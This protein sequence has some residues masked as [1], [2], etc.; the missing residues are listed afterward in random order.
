MRYRQMD[1]TLNLDPPL[2]QNQKTKIQLVLSL[3]FDVSSGGAQA[4]QVLLVTAG[5]GGRAYRGALE[6]ILGRARG[7]KLLS[8]LDLNSLS[9]TTPSPSPPS[10][11][12]ALREAVSSEGNEKS[13]VAVVVDCLS[14]AA[15]LFPWMELAAAVASFLAPPRSSS[16]SSALK[17]SSSSSPLPKSSPSSSASVAA[18][19]VLVLV[20]SSSS[21]QF[22]D[23]LCDMAATRLRFGPSPPPAA[24]RLLAAAG[25]GAGAGAATTTASGRKTTPTTATTNLPP[26]SLLSAETSRASGRVDV[27]RTLVSR[28][29]TGKIVAASAAAG[30][31]ATAAA[32]TTNVP[33]SSPSSALPSFAA[34]PRPQQR[35]PFLAAGGMRLGLT[36]AEEAARAAVELPHESVGWRSRKVGEEDRN[37]GASVVAARP[38]AAAAVGAGAEEEREEPA[39]GGRIHYTRDS[40]TDPDSDE[41]P[42]D[43]LDP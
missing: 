7:K 19:C 40:D 10:L 25:A 20:S 6:G 36:P 13:G 17:S 29:S 21:P 3:A 23:S 41:D 1:K 34:S 43:A 33:S 30:A 35:P 5:R 22:H 39:L 4:D 15:L 9:S 32:K 27:E 31:A 8:T 28:D 12:S 26:E 11:A 16:S 2:F 38:R 42:D 18:A 14:S 37:G 24:L